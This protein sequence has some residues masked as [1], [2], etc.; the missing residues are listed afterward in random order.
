MTHAMVLTGVHLDKNGLPV[1]WRV[2]NSYG[3]RGWGS[4]ESDKGYMVRPP[5]AASKP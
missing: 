1:R 5:I 2:E 3:P 4:V